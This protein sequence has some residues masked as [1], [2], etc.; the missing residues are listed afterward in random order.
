MIVQKLIALSIVTFLMCS[1]AAHL[2]EFQE[3]ESLGKGSH[4]GAAGIFGGAPW[5]ELGASVFHSAG[6]SETT[7]WSTQCT[8]MYSLNSDFTSGMSVLTGPKLQLNDRLALSVPFGTYIRREYAVNYSA[9]LATPTLYIALPSK[10][11]R[12]E[13]LFFV[14][15]EL[16]NDSDGDWYG[17]ATLG[18]KRSLLGANDLRTA[19]NV[20]VTAL[21]IYGGL[22]FDL[23]R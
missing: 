4:R 2:P 16:I 15:S 18:Y 5:G 6:V 13:Q 11:S 9:F 21:G 23:F 12:L 20:N 3:I 10:N 7:D 19:L 17:W 1:C 22:T 8:Y 14:R